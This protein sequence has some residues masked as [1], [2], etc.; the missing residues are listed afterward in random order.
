MLSASFMQL[1]QLKLLTCYFSTEKW[2]AQEQEK[3]LVLSL[4]LLNRP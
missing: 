3:L 4:Q 2:A 1:M